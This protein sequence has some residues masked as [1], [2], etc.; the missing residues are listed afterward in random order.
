MDRTPTSVG[1]RHIEPET[2]IQRGFALEE[3]YV[4]SGSTGQHGTFLCSVIIYSCQSQWRE[5]HRDINVVALKH[6]IL[7]ITLTSP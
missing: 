2:N 5:K 6:D 3:E 7:F 1:S 4:R